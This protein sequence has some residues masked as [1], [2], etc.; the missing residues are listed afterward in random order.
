MKLGFIFPGQGSQTPGMGKDI[1]NSYPNYREVYDKASHILGINIANLTFNS[2]EE[3]LSQ[4]ANSQIAIFVMSLALLEVLQSYKIKAE[5]LSGLS[6]GEYSALS[7][8]N[9]F[10]FEDGLNIVKSRGEIMRK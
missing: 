3:I 6:L 9:A 8:A 1:Y 5:Y 10:S 7:Y 2:T 4:T